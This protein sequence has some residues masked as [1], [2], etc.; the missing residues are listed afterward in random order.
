VLG[1]TAVGRAGNRE[2]LVA[3]PERLESARGEKGQHLEGFGAGAP[4]GERV[5]VARCA[6]KLVTISYYSRVYPVL[7]FDRITAGYSN[8]ELVRLDHTEG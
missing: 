2:L 1:L 8:I 4:V 3:P 5:G 7:G 6:D